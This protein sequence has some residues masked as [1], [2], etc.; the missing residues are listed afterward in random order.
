MGDGDEERR[1]SVVSPDDG[2]ESIRLRVVLV[3]QTHL[4]VFEQLLGLSIAV[5]IYYWLEEC[6]LVLQQLEKST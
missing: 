5:Y 6:D 3:S 2:F 4:H 1:E